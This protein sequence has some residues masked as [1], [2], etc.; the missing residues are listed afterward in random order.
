MGDLNAEA[1]RAQRIT[2]EQAKSITLGVIKEAK[3]D[4]RAERS[5]E[6]NFLMEE[7]HEYIHKCGRT[8]DQHIHYP[9][10]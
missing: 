3:G 8:Q 10:R 5:C 2:L 4:L 7:E 6:F 1:R 9:F